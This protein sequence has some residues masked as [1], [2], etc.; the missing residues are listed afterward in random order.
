MLPDMTVTLTGYAGRRYL[1]KF[2]IRAETTEVYLP[3]RGNTAFA[4]LVLARLRDPKHGR[5]T[6]PNIAGKAFNRTSAIADIRAALEQAFGD[7]QLGHELIENLY[8]GEYALC[9]PANAIFIEPEFR[10]LAPYHLA[11]AVVT[12]IVCRAGRRVR[13][14]LL[15]VN[16]GFSN[17]FA[18]PDAMA[19]HLRFPGHV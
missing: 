4:D 17:P 1:V 11:E 12:A 6:L 2:T 14:S 13:H 10:R 5:S 16:R 15:A 19:T 18:Q 3:G 8:W 7:P 9:L